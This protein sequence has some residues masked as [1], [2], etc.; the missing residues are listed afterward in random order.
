MLR[1]NK[2]WL[3]PWRPPRSPTWLR[4]ESADQ[5]RRELQSNRD[6]LS[7]TLEGLCGD[8]Q[9]DQLR[10]RLAQLRAASRPNPTSFTTDAPQPVP[11]STRPRPLARQ[12]KPNA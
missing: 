5:R 6:Q 3:P 2:N 8:E 7:A 12:R 11:N 9:V 10:A 4:H 1:H